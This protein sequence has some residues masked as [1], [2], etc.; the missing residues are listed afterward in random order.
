MATATKKK[1]IVRKKR[2]R[3]SVPAKISGES[4]TKQAFKDESDANNILKKY[5]N[6]GD[7]ADLQKAH[8]VFLDVSEMGDYQASL[9]AVIAAREAFDALPSKVKNAFDNDPG[10]LVDA[11]SNPEMKGKLLEL[12]LIEELEADVVPSASSSQPAPENTGEAPSSES[13]AV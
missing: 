3:I 6:S 4:M 2:D 1:V 10:A 12:G 9:N 7:V 11:V 5:V 8:G 13:T